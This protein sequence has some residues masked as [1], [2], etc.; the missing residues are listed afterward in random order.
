[1]NEQLKKLQIFNSFNDEELSLL[2]KHFAHSHYDK[3]EIIADRNITQKELY[4]I[5]SGKIVSTI[6]LPGNI[7]RKSE[8]YAPGDFFGEMS[9]FGYKLP[10]DT[11]HAAEECNVLILTEK[12]ILELIEKNSDTAIKLMSLLLSLTVLH[13]RNSSKFLA[14]VVQWGENASRRVITD[15]LT[16]LYN[17]AFLDDAL[18]NFFY[19]SKSNNKPL[20]FLMLDLD[21]FRNI[22]QQ[23]S[24]ETGNNIL[25]ELVNLIKNKISSHGIIARYGGDE[26][27]V[28]L[29][30]TDLKKAE[31]IA[32]EIRADVEK[33]DFSKHLEGKKMQVTISIGISSFPDTATELADFKEKADSS[34]YLAKKSGRNRVAHVD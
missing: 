11:F 1:M 25:S 9:L 7:H 34:L 8:E 4:I 33:H 16:G 24:I 23:F 29:P 26:Y 13:L 17:R 12:S 3:D 27:S 28:L 20:S 31:K 14:D 30:E 21:N 5:L 10:F 18:E 2:E 22:N 15:E 32:E 6:N 19:I